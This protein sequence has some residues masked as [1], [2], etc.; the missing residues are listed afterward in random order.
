MLVHMPVVRAESSDIAPLSRYT[1]EPYMSQRSPST[2]VT[3]YVCVLCKMHT[4]SFPQAMHRHCYEYA[5]EGPRYGGP[6][7]QYRARWCIC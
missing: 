3:M 5:K 1:N 2:I 4:I 7:R 6:L